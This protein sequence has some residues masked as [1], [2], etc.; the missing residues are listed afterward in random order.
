MRQRFKAFE[1]TLVKLT[2]RS[3]WAK[4]KAVCIFQNN[5]TSARL[6]VKDRETVQ[7]HHPSKLKLINLILKVAHNIRVV[8]GPVWPTF[9]PASETCMSRDMFSLDHTSPQH[10]Q[11]TQSDWVIHVYVL[12]LAQQLDSFSNITTASCLATVLFSVLIAKA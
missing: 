7:G 9:K 8:A 2:V 11:F 10:K 5:F 12:Q 1:T 6:I 3:G 4:M